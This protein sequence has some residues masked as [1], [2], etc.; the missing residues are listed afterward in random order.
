MKEDWNNFTK[1]DAKQDLLDLFFGES[2][3]TVDWLISH[4]FDYG[5]GSPEGEGYQYGGPQRG[6]TDED[7]WYVKF[8][9]TG[10]GYGNW[11]KETGEMFD[12]IIADY[13]KGRRS[14]SAGSRS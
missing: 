3:K 9:Y 1:G 12:A 13:E 7:I 6:F 10:Q 8:Q 4:G 14:V 2:G 11:K 5:K